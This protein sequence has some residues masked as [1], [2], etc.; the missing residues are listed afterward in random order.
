VSDRHDPSDHLA[1]ALNLG[2]RRAQEAIERAA[3]RHADRLET[4]ARHT[5]E[6]W[7]SDLARGDAGKVW[8]RQREAFIE[9]LTTPRKE[10]KAARKLDRAR[11]RLENQRLKTQLQAEKD[12]LKLQRTTAGEGIVGVG[13]GLIMA[14]TALFN[15][16]LWWMVFPAFGIGSWGARVLSTKLSGRST[17]AKQTALPVAEDPRDTRV[18]AVCARITAELGRA[19]PTVR[20]L[21]GKNEKVVEQ[22][23]LT[24]RGLTER[25]RELRQLC[26]PADDA[27]LQHE[28]ESLVTR[29]GAERDTVIVARLQGALQA[30]DGQRQQRAELSIAAARFEAEHTRIAYTLEGLHTQ[31]LRLRSSDAAS[32][33]P[34]S[35]ALRQSLNQL[36][37]EMDAVA[38]AMDE[39]HRADL[40]PVGTVESLPP[41]AR[42][43]ERE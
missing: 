6:P 36:G 23:R 7:L 40:T 5:G 22:L 43:R 35:A 25:E 38:S 11:V 14:G 34:A 27:R 31:L 39:V 9:R 16:E 21:V 33:D 20:E 26:N 15:H 17:P 2:L 30:L 10:R 19:A 24:C 41:G 12:A 37:E 4:L 32:M 1:V 3:R 28:H 8:S 42:T 29:I 18:D 13:A